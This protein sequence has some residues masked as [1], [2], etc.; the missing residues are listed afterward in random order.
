MSMNPN[1]VD[2]ATPMLDAFKKSVIDKLTEDLMAQIRPKV[3]KAAEQAFAELQA[4]VQSEYSVVD[5]RYVM[6]PIINPPKE[7]AAK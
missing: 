6:K 7:G 5:A 3:V 1:N 4:M 2:L